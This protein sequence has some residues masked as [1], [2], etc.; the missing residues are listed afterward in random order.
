MKVT[1]PE[2]IEAGE[3]EL[4]AA[5][6]DNLDRAVLQQ[7]LKDRIDVS[8]VDLKRGDIVA[9]GDQVAY[10]L[11]LE[12]KVDFRV[13]LDR[14]GN[15]LPLA[16]GDPV[17]PEQTGQTG[18]PG[19]PQ[20]AEAFGPDGQEEGLPGAD[21]LSGEPLDGP[22]APGAPSVMD[23]GP[24]DPGLEM[25]ETAP[26]P[27]TPPGEAGGDPTEDLDAVLGENRRFWAEREGSAGIS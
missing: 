14:S 17:E 20:A 6:R 13:L 10:Q 21:S 4:I 18:H 12:L 7:L 3:S 24:L 11:D 25:E 5:I 22:D 1:D 2:V 16:Q 15:W 8:R 9:C 19:E 23:E 26:S 27:E